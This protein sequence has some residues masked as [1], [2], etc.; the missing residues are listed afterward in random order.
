LTIP[1]TVRGDPA[2]LEQVVLIL[3]DNAVKYNRAGGR[4]AVAV[5]RRGLQAAVEVCDTGCGLDPDDLPR[6]FARFHRGRRAG[7]SAEGSGLGLAIAQG[8][9]HAHGGQ[10]A[11]A[12]ATGSGT[13][14]TITLP[15]AA[16]REAAVRRGRD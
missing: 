6:L 12:S 10:I 1:L 4:V 13:C 15:L 14:A 8:I 9:V 3:L 2:R 5:R 16:T 7:Q 11:I